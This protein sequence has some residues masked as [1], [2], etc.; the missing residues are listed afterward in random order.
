VPP[1]TAGHGQC[2]RVSALN[3]KVPI[4]VELSDEITL[5]LPVPVFM[6]Q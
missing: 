5:R 2:L 4:V 6:S 1:V 3:A